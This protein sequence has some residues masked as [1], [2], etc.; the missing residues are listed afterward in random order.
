MIPITFLGTSTAPI[1]A[2]A[3]AFFAEDNPN[4]A[5]VYADVP[6]LLAAHQLGITPTAPSLPQWQV[7]TLP[8]RL[9]AL[10]QQLEK[11]AA[12]APIALSQ[13]AWLHYRLLK[14]AEHE[15]Q[16]TVIEHALLLAL[17]KPCPRTMLEQEVLAQHENIDS[18]ALDAHLYRLRQKLN[19][20]KL[21]VK[22]KDGLY[23]LHDIHP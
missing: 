18:H 3:C 17:R 21:D 13:N 19:I 22:V 20:F 15:S 14:N 8:V 4:A 5:V 9:H 23:C 10:R 1:I 16:I 2:Q 11:L 6:F 12:F 7:V